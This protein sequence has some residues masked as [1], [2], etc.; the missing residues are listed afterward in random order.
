MPNAKTHRKA[1]AIA[2]GTT[3]LIEAI[4][5]RPTSTTLQR[6]QQPQSFWR[7]IWRGFLRVIEVAGKTALGAFIGALTARL[8]D[9]IE[10]AKHP[11][12]RGTAHS[13]SVLVGLII[14]FVRRRP[15][16]PLSIM[17]RPA[18]AGYGSHL[19]LDANTPKGLPIC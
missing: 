8:P 17:I 14:V 15:N 5:E 16:H 3:A 4:F 11:N 7:N 12:H 10:P 2:G 13:F 19:A 9:L 18:L 1:G 6:V